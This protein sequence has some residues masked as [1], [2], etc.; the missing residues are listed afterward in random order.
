MLTALLTLVAVALFSAVYVGVAL[1]IAAFIG[2]V[3]PW[4]RSRGGR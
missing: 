3:P 4:L 1:L 2:G